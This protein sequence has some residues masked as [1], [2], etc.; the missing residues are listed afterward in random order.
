MNDFMAPSRLIV[1]KRPL[2]RDF[3][4]VP[5]S[6]FWT[7]R[8]PWEGIG[9]L[10]FLLSLKSGTPISFEW[11]NSVTP[12]G[13]HATR[14]AS[15]CL[16]DL[17]YLTRT[18]MRAGNGQVAGWSW[19]VRDEPVGT[20]AGTSEA[21]K[22]RVENCSLDVSRQASE[23]PVSM[24][25]T[26]DSA[27]RPLSPGHL[28]VVRGRHQSNFTIL[29]NALFRTGQ[30]PWEG[31]GLHTFLLSLK[32]GRS[33]SQEWLSRKT[34]SRRKA[35]ETAVGQLES[36]DYLS[37]SK[38]RDARGQ[39]VGWTWVVSDEPR[40][41]MALRSSPAESTKPAG[42]APA[43]APA[44]DSCPDVRNQHPVAIRS[45][46]IPHVR[47]QHPAPKRAD[48][49][50]DAGNRQLEPRAC[51]YPPSTRDRS[52]A[53]LAS[54]RESAWAVPGSNESC[55]PAGF[56]PVEDAQC[57]YSPTLLSTQASSKNT[58]AV[59]CLEN[60]V[61]PAFL[62]ADEQSVALRLVAGFDRAT[63]QEL[64][65]ELAGADEAGVIQTSWSGYL[66]R[67]AERARVGTF[68]RERCV[69][70]A[71]ARILREHRR[72]SGSDTKNPLQELLQR[73]PQSPAAAEAIAS[74]AAFLRGKAN[75]LP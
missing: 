63:A 33:I 65:D 62:T 69:L 1:C 46:E 72:R 55:P 6:L 9:L 36:A 58:K 41:S 56:P 28:T 67:L 20:E 11:L 5:N 42:H 54:A 51:W 31:I 14:S 59:T 38:E 30:L 12:S 45:D 44:L 29:P 47:N 66:Y 8:L 16:E 4:I 60:L 2:A 34:K 71:E 25:H 7:G 18:H 40:L 52:H 39:I 53:R 24:L 32:S 15:S 17:G 70:I 21:D 68:T 49:I 43:E 35:T 22:L 3:T 37:R 75:A 73:E 26:D 74:I 27:F 23:L 61:F 10:N 19:V 50:P 48:E 57:R 13:R 64:L